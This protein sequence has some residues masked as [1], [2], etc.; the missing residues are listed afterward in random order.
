[1]PGESIEDV[2]RF[3][4]HSSLAVTTTYLRRLEGQEDWGGDRWR[5]RS[6]WAQWELPA[7]PA[8][9]SRRHINTIRMA[10]RP[11]QPRVAY[12]DTP[13]GLN[14]HAREA[15]LHHTSNNGGKVTVGLDVGDKH[16]H[17][18]FIDADGQ[19]IEEARLAATAAAPYQRFGAGGRY[20]V[21]LEAGLHSPWL[22]RLLVDLGQETYAANPRR[23]RAIYSNES[24][25]HRVGRRVP[26][27]HR[28]RGPGLAV[29]APLSLG[30]D[31]S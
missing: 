10:R 23:L 16:V 21:I 1:M 22:S 27:S 18:C 8:N 17:A 20:R 31:Q 28:A 2:S 4:D 6:G 9:P 15:T 25:S 29:P 30:R 19:I 11:P 12:S 13:S 26:R 5:R 24:K 3:L 14:A 7:S